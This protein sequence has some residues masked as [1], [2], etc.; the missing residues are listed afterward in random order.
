[1][2]ALET[3]CKWHQKHTTQTQHVW[4]P[5]YFLWAKEPFVGGRVAYLQEDKNDRVG[6]WTSGSSYLSNP[7]ATVW[8]GRAPH[9]SPPKPNTHVIIGG[10]YLQSLG[11]RIGNRQKAHVI[12]QLN[13][14]RTK[15]VEKT[16]TAINFTVELGFFCRREGG[17][18][19]PCNLLWHLDGASR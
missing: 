4:T 17:F 9:H 1:M 18:Y 6:S 13:F 11:N 15:D 3:N 16:S 2:S 7:W 10:I 8:G 5:L 19:C 12:W 14:T